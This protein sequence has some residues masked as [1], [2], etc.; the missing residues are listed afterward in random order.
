M[1]FFFSGVGVNLFNCCVFVCRLQCHQI[2][3]TTGEKLKKSHSA[4]EL[5]VDEVY[6]SDRGDHV[7]QNITKDLLS[8]PKE[9][10]RNMWQGFRVD[11]TSPNKQK[12]SS[13]SLENHPGDR[14]ATVD[15]KQVQRSTKGRVRSKEEGW[16]PQVT[17]PKPFQMTL[18]ETEYKHKVVRSRAEIEQENKELRREIEEL[19]ECQRKFRA[20]AVPAHVHMPLY[21]EL[22]ER[23][24]ERRRQLRAAEQ[25]RLLITQRPF[26]FLEREQ[27]KKQQKELI[28]EQKDHRRW[29]FRAKPVPLAVKEAATGER[30]K[31]EQLYREIKKEMRATEMLL[32]ANEPPSMLSKRISER[33]MQ[34]QERS[35]P[36]TGIR[37]SSQ[38]P[39]FNASYR[40]FQKQLERKREFRPLTAC[41][42]FKLC[43]ANINP[44]KE[45]LTVE[46]E[47]GGRSQSASQGLFV[48]LSPQTPSSSVCSSLSGSREYLP[49]KI[50]DA[51]KKRQEA[52]R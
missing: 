12:P 9:H 24:E 51:A 10:I 41:E 21:E 3:G 29:A 7:N 36:T 28:K 33:R 32:S 49:T 5:Y 44:R 50:T 23:D 20:T 6:N 16:R 48:S 17:V 35:A 19:T 45:H 14:Q 11:K 13:T 31:E 27:I 22:R 25:R 40:R 34:R 38:V 46:T 30:Q 37:I 39:D 2:N 43:T 8:S 52:V 15:P 26:S 42:P 47:E 1:S 4:H 18:R